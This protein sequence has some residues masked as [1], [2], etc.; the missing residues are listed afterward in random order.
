[1]KAFYSGHTVNNSSNVQG[2]PRSAL[3]NKATCGLSKEPVISDCPASPT[4][5][6]T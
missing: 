5:R 2:D 3:Y 6:R 4:E 1:M